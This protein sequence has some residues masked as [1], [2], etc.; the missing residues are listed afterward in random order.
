VLD[1]DNPRGRLLA[2]LMHIIFDTNIHLIPD[3]FTKLQLD[4]FRDPVTNKCMCAW[5]VVDNIP[6]SE[7]ATLDAHLNLHQ[8]LMIEYPKRNWEYCKSAID[9][10][11]GRW[12][13]ELDSF[14]EDL[15]SRVNQYQ[16]TEPEDHW[17]GS[18]L[19]DLA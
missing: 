2:N 19:R 9:A 13:G 14:Y 10:L 18:I 12:N 6:L 8:Q 11:L 4:T 3:S 15:L 7:F 16:S 1:P 17:D 5:C